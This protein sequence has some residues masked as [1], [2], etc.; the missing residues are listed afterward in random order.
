MEILTDSPFIIMYD[1]LLARIADKVPKIKF[2]TFDFSQFEQEQPP[3]SWPCLL[4]DF[5][6]FNFS[7]LSENV[8]VASGYIGLRLGF[9]PYSSVSSATPVDFR[10]KGLEYF[11]IEWELHKAL[12]G[13]SPGDDFGN[14]SRVSA[15]TDVERVDKLRI[16]DLRYS[17][18]FEDYSVKKVT[19][20]L[21]RSAEVRPELDTH[22]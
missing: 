18:G 1:A 5:E 12:H 21:K 7:D 16:R 15:R 13:W 8:Q 22:N 20:T 19:T 2:T 4:I 3:V 9:N 14:L 6:T 10:N 17:I 11:V